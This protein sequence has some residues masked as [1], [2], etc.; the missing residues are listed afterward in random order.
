MFYEGHEL[1]VFGVVAHLASFMGKYKIQEEVKI[2]GGI[3]KG[4]TGKII[5][6]GNKI[7]AYLV[8]ID[9]NSYH[10]SE[11]QLNKA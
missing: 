11:S 10:I 6:A 7:T 4:K 9:G 8:S 1:R 2:I 3:H 5:L